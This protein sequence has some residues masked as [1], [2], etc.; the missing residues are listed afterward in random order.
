MNQG[1]NKYIENQRCYINYHFWDNDSKSDLVSLADMITN[2]WR[3]QA[4]NLNRKMQIGDT[5]ETN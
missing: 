2:D 5:F 3:D 1:F 4:L